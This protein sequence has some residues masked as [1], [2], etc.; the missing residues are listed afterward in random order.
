MFDVVVPDTKR[1]GT[2]RRRKIPKSHVPAAWKALTGLGWIF[3][4]MK[5]SS[6]Y[7]PEF[8]LGDEFTN[9]SL[10][11]RCILYLGLLVCG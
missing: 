1:G 10:L 7:T 6:I 2:K 3:A 9:Y 5:M 11:G 8:V 4:F